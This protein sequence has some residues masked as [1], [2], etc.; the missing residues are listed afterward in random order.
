[1]VTKNI[2]MVVSNIMEIIWLVCSVGDDEQ[3]SIN[4]K[5]M[6]EDV[7]RL[8]VVINIYNCRNRE[9]H[10]GMIKTVLHVL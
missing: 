3:I 9:Q 7:T 2:Q 5:E 6:P 4:L 1:M 8:A 10:F